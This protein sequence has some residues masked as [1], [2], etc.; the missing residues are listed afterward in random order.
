MRHLV[1]F[2]LL[3][4]FLTLAATGVMAFVR[5]FSLVSTRVHIVF[6]L[7]SLVLVGLHLASRVGYFRSQIRAS[8][9]QRAGIRRPVLLGIAGGWLL[10]LVIALRGWEPS[11]LL[12]DQSYEARRRA[13]IVRTSSLVGFQDPRTH[14]RLI[15]RAPGGRADVAL[16]LTIRFGE[17]FAVPPSAAVWAE[18]TTGA[19][20]ETLYL[21]ESL[22]F[23]DT[24]MWGG[25]RTP[26]HHILPLWRHRYTLVSGIDPTGEVDAFS[27][28]TP[29]H[30]F[31]LDDY[32]ELGEDR[33]FVLCVEVNA[34]GDLNQQ[35]PDPHVGQPSLLYTAY[36]ELDSD[37]PYALLE[38]TGHGG[39]ARDSGAIHYDFDGITTAKNLIDLLLV[40]IEGINPANNGAAPREP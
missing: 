3:F 34:P 37:Q 22:A 32:L 33:S 15:A 19:M 16:S 24:P 29:T 5:P 14:R 40:K 9:A 10:L 4:S 18:T 25:K 8:V 27:A 11:Q 38:L 26:R 35:F 1:N 20:I 17:G 12:I 2:G 21:D 36:L 28:A 13:E 6:G 31:T 30:S 7:V 39:G 23:S